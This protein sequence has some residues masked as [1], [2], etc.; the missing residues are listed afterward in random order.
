MNI[1]RQT[2]RF[3]A[4][5]LRSVTIAGV[6]LGVM[7]CR[8]PDE[9]DV[10]EL[11]DFA[12]QPAVDFGRAYEIGQRTLEGFDAGDYDAF[13]E[14][15]DDALRA[16]IDPAGFAEFRGSFVGE[17]GDFEYIYEVDLADGIADGVINYLYTARFSEGD[18]L[19]RLAFQED[20]EQVVGIQI[21]D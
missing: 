21:G 19:M 16:G 6:T 8:E 4:H 1:L 15:W 9:F 3:L 5:N 20:G 18:V 7:A 10:G 13:A 17:H 14:H 2:F 12:A 11:D